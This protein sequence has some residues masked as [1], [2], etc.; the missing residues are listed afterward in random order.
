MVTLLILLSCICWQQRSCLLLRNMRTC[1]EISNRIYRSLYLPISL[2]TYLPTYLSIYLC[3]YLSVS[4]LYVCTHANTYIYIHKHKLPYYFMLLG[5]PWS[6]RKPWTAAL[7]WVPPTP[8]SRWRPRRTLRQYPGSA[9]PHSIPTSFARGTP[10]K[11]AQRIATES[12]MQTWQ[13]GMCAQFVK[14]LG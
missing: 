6:A 10:Q 9:P 7:T 8:A 4:S 14:I 11:A 1:T 3:F 5:R 2:S 12:Y 13:L